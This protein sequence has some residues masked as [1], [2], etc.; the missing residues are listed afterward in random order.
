[1]AAL[2]GAYYFTQ[3]E[4]SPTRPAQMAA[5][6]YKPAVLNLKNHLGDRGAGAPTTGPEMPVLPRNRLDLTIILP[7]GSEAGVYDVQFQDS[8]H[9]PLISA[10]ATAAIEHDD[11]MVRMKWNLTKYSGGRYVVAW[12]QPPFG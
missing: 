9:R 1:M 5:V 2:A 4:W 12:R 10:A 6:E 7:F 3:R 11:T 8:G